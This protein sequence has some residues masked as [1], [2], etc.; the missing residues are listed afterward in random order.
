MATTKVVRRVVI[1][2]VALVVLTLIYMVASTTKIYGTGPVLADSVGR[3]GNDNARV[4]QTRPKEQV[5]VAEVHKDLPCTVVNPLNHQFIDLSSLS[6]NDEGNPL[7]WVS[8]SFDKLRNYT[9]G[10]CSYPSKNTHAF[11]DLNST[12]VGGYYLQ[13][14]TYSSIGEFSTVPKFRGKKLVLTY[15]NG[16]YCDNLIDSKTGQKLRKSSII[17]FT[18]DREMMAKASIQFVAEANDCTYFFEVRSHHACP[19]AP[20]A[21]NLAAVWIFLLI[22]LA[23]GSVYFSGE[24]L[25]KHLKVKK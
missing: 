20:K 9:L 2:L 1:P 23:A 6:V 15:E 13:N 21:N 12:Q 14:G 22:V 19:T 17:T 7:P 3:S 25:Y 4:P 11:Q 10:I 8:K 24:L 16:S 5:E 18:C